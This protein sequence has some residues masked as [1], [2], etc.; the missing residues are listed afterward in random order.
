MKGTLLILFLFLSFKVH[1]ACAQQTNVFRG[2]VLDERRRPVQFATVYI[3][4]LDYTT[5]SS[6]R[7]EFSLTYPSTLNQ[8]SIKITS[9]G[10]ISLEQKIDLKAVPSPLVFVLKDLTLTLSEVTINPLFGTALK[11]NSS[12]VFDQEAIERTQAFSLMDIL[13]TIPGRAAVSPDINSPQTI[14]LRGNLGGNYDLNNSLGVPI[15]LDGVVQ[16]NDAN[17]QA[18]SVGLWGMAGSILG[19]ANATSSSDVPF[20]GMDLREIPTET[21]E[22][23]EVIQGVASAEYGEM[24]D[25]AII[26]DRKAAAGPYQFTTNINGGSTSY[27]LGK[28]FSLP[29]QMGALNLGLNYTSSNPDP[30]DN[31]KQYGRIA[32]SLIWSKNFGKNIRNTFNI[33]Y[34]RRDDDVKQDPD[35]PNRQL[36]YSKSSGLKLSNRLAVS[37][38]SPFARK[39]NLTLSYSESNQHTY[40]QWLLNQGPKGYTSKDTT[41]IYE[42]ELLSGRYLAE[43][44]IVG[45]PVT[46]S[47]NLRL[48]TY[49]SIGDITHAITYGL[50]YNYSNNGGKGIV[51]D[52]DRPRWVNQNGQNARPYSF[53]QIDPMQNVGLY[54]MD[55]FSFKLF[56]KHVSSNFG[57]RYD[58]QNS[59][60]TLQPR[61]SSAIKL[62]KKW[63]LNIAYG[64]SAKGPTLAHRYPSPTWTDIP[65][66]LAYNSVDALYLVYTEKSVSDNSRLKPSKSEQLELGARYQGGFINSQLNLYYKNNSDGF[67]PLKSFKQ[68][69]LPVYEYRYDEASKQMVYNQTGAMQTF[70]NYGSYAI[71]N[72]QNSRTFG[73]DWILSTKP[74]SSINTSI[75]TSTSFIIGKQN[76]H[77]LDMVDLSAPLPIA[78]EN[79]WYLLFP[80]SSNDL[81]YNLTSKLGTTTHIPK[82]GFVVMTTL[83]VY[84]FSR[85]VSRYKDNV[86]QAVGYVGPDGSSHFFN[87]ANNIPEAVRSLTLINSDPPK[88]YA[89]INLSVAKEI[90]KS[91]RLGIAAYNVFNIQ[92]E[93][94]K[95][96]PASGAETIIDLFNTPATI[97]GSITV[98]F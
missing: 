67:G 60:F 9:V 17:M 73:S 82:I 22:K 79:I 52:P 71:G 23:V 74:I 96:D 50:S 43:E 92:P 16:S 81:K 5:S 25:G 46:A 68:Y 4:E 27:S 90:K 55:N 26:I 94:I 35:D 1:P 83:D 86:Q 31:I 78:G 18:R 19:G 29:K 11:S 57:L 44:E 34:N 48:N 47:A 14:T 88:P 36:S 62:N 49:F 64:I 69:N 87:P 32:T 70:T 53:E 37:L 95:K 41:G 89:N 40:K 66:I 33:D 15:I 98:K 59:A 85:T 42:G 72:I 61:L 91:I 8:L 30:R 28:G 54:A 97:T 7:G 65:L 93:Q 3:P 21:I 58:R 80:P 39:L 12:I 63:S 75:T 51:S 24:T 84:W 45:N 77:Q 38:R 13:N 2:Q 76:N 6:V 20:Q 56:G 10:K